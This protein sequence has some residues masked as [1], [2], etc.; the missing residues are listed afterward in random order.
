MDHHYYV[1]AN[2]NGTTFR[3]PFSTWSE[4]NSSEA[5]DIGRAIVAGMGAIFEYTEKA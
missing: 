4:L 2:L 3:M 1:H 5:D